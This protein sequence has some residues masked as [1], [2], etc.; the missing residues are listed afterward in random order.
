MVKSVAGNWGG[1][2][3][4]HAA[5]IIMSAKTIRIRIFIP[6][7][8]NHFGAKYKAYTLSPM[9]MSAV[10]QRIPLA[11]GLLLHL[12]VYVRQK[13]IPSSDMEVPTKNGLYWA[14]HA[15]TV[16]LANPTLASTMLI[17]H[18][19]AP[20][21]AEASAPSLKS[22]FFISTPPFRSLLSPRQ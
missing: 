3:S 11:S 15:P 13:E 21:K 5:E 1:N 4:E 2:P 8:Q 14:I 22:E 20:I 17:C 9:L 16:M 18:K 7:S 19:K 10:I 12:P 6:T